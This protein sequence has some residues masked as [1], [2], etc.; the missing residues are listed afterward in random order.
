MAI[1]KIQLTI[2]NTI[3]TEAKIA[4]LGKEVFGELR[5]AGL[6]TQ[7]REFYETCEDKPSWVLNVPAAIKAGHEIVDE[8]GTHVFMSRKHP[9]KIAICMSGWKES[10]KYKRLDSVGELEAFV[11]SGT[12]QEW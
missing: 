9:G 1:V 11:A 5:Q 8:Y 3:P 12:F 10:S 7:K 2:K 4:F 6:I